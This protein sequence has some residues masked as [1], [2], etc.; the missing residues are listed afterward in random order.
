MKTLLN[1][2]TANT[3]KELFTEETTITNR[4]HGVFTNLQDSITVNMSKLPF[5]HPQITN[6][7]KRFAFSNLHTSIIY[8]IWALQSH[9]PAQESN[10]GTNAAVALALSND[11][12]NPK[13]TLGGFSTPGH[14]PSFPA[15]LPTSHALSSL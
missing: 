12:Q 2:K 1:Y 5:G 14:L 9:F 10:S 4:K 7:V 3:S 8:S 6:V 13:A 15:S 11:S